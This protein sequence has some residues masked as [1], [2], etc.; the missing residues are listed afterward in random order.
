M[1]IGIGL[2][3]IGPGVSSERVLSF[4]RAAEAAGFDYV[5]V[6]DHVVL[7]R[8]GG[9]GYPYSSSGR[10]EL[11]ASSIFLEPLTLLA[12]VAAATSRIGLATAVLVAPMR[13][14]VLHAKVIATLD[15]LSG[16]RFILGAGVGWWREEFEALGVPFHTRGRRMDEWLQLVRLLWSGEPVDFEGEFYK[17]SG[18][19]SHPKPAHEIPL[20]LGGESLRQARRVGRYANGWTVAG[21]GLERLDE[22]MGEARRAAEAAGR[23]PGT[24]RVIAPAGQI[25]AGS[26][27]AIEERARELSSLG[28]SGVRVGVPREVERPETLIEAFGREALPA[29]K[30]L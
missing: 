26:F 12:Y 28:V 2:A 4:A 17:V 29:I 19:A 23:D 16:G 5:S 21:A 3:Q 30:D 14:P 6:V 25:A 11:P 10:L 24:L 9:E 7:H 18:F 22:F 8:D 15:H 13:E 27:A 20:Y 1:E